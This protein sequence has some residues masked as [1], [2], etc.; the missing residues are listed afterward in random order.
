MRVEFTSDDFKVALATSVVVFG[1][2]G[3]NLQVLIAKKAGMPYEGATILPS[4]VVRPSEDVEATARGLVERVTG[5]QDWP[6]EQLNAHADVYRNPVGRVVNISFYCL[7]KLDEEL[8]SSLKKE[9]YAW[10][11]ASEVPAMAY[12]HDEVLEYAKERLKRRVKRRPIGFSLLPKEFTMAQ[13]QRLYECALGKSFDKRNF[14]RKLLKSSLL[15]ETDKTTK[16][17]STQRRKRM[18]KDHISVPIM[19]CSAKLMETPKEK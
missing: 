10:V 5:R 6:L 13:I 12:D 15:L 2:D 8:Q 14:R 1:F 9:N 18:K 7:I 19:K 17:G 3:D 11:N 4:T 16:E